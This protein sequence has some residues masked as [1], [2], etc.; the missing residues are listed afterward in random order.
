MMLMTIFPWHK[1]W[2]ECHEEEEASGGQGDAS[3]TGSD[4]DALKTALN[5]LTRDMV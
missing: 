1:T 2:L 3:G 4:D 5:I